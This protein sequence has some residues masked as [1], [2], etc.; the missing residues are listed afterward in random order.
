MPG[1]MRVLHTSDTPE[2][3][4][5]EKLAHYRHYHLPLPSNLHLVIRTISI[6]VKQILDLREGEVRKALRVS[7]E[8]M[9][10]PD[11]ENENHH[12]REAISQAVGRALCTA[13]FRGLLTRS[14]AVDPCLNTVVFMNALA[15]RQ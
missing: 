14:A 12:G 2:H 5:S 7:E 13:G 9:L 10:A 1:L 11:W 6:D 8:R 4:V 3:A 15:S